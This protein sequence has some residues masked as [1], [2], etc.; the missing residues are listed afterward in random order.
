MAIVTGQNVNDYVAEYLR[1]GQI[2]AG[3]NDTNSLNEFEKAV[4]NVWER[5]ANA[6]GRAPDMTQQIQ[7]FD[8]KR[9]E[10]RKNEI[11]AEIAAGQEKEKRQQEIESIAQNEALR[12][13]EAQLQK[14][15][16]DIFGKAEQAGVERI[17]E[18]FIPAR[19]K[20]IAEEAALGRLTS[21]VS[22]VPLSKIDQQKQLAMSQLFGDIA[23]QKAAG[24][25]D[26]SKTIESILASEREAARQG[27]QFE[28]ELGLRREGLA[29][30][31]RA[32]DLD[33]MIQQQLGQESNILKGKSL[34]GG[35]DWLD[36]FTGVTGGIKNIVGAGSDA[37]SAGKNAGKTKKG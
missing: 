20:A 37:Y 3:I 13:N 11:G 10:I 21:P 7:Q 32:G 31:T 35:R 1:T 22:I 24:Q 2:P 26:V 29:A 8:T 19:Q 14:T 23:G 18:Q 9:N 28:Q 34:D 30:Q 36:Y 17:N 5:T 12:R 6:T 16:A 27:K 15:L 25:L 4:R 33:R